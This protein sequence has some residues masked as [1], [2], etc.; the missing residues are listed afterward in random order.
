MVARVF[1]L[2]FEGGKDGICKQQWVLW[3]LVPCPIKVFRAC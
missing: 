2:L 3:L 1:L